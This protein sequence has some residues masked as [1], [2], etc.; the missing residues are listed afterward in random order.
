MHGRKI[1]ERRMLNWNPE[2][3]LKFENERTQA[4]IDLTARIALAKPE[5]VIDIGCGPGNS[6]RILLNR[7]PKARLT[8]LDN[9]VEM[10][11]KAKA[12]L[13]DVE[14]IVGDASAFAFSDKYDLVFS[15]AALQ[16]MQNHET[17]LPGLYAAVKPG[18]A[19]AVQVPADQDSAVRRSLLSVSSRPGWSRYTSGCEGMINYRSAEYYYDIVAGLSNRFDI[20]ETIYYH[21]L[22]SPRGVMEWYKGT[23]M[24]PFLE[25][26]PDEE[27]K[28]EF[29]EEV[30][31]GCRNY[32][33]VRGDGK[34][35]Y[36]FKRIFFTAYK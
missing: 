15:N 4:S 30:F 3:Y 28:R 34:V 31:A 24:R 35:L 17:L 2:Q 29:E 1:Y 11:R 9:S 13:P 26:L 7:W 21:I 33:R 32:Y 25:S 6:T 22:G 36:P 12:E 19:L 18:G 23:A 27:A 16:W 5:T 8:G 20:W 10:I 14:W